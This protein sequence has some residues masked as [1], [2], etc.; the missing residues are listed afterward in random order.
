MSGPRLAKAAFKHA[1]CP[2]RG[3]VWEK[4]AGGCQSQYRAFGAWEGCVSTTAHG[5]NRSGS[6]AI[7]GNGEGISSQEFGRSLFGPRCGNCRTRCEVV[8][9]YCRSGPGLDHLRALQRKESDGG[10]EAFVTISDN[11][12]DCP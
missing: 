7:T 5:R 4:P 6:R 2:S 1:R 11:A 12:S 9:L 10:L 8:I 3:K